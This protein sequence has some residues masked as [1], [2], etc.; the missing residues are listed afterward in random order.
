MNLKPDASKASLIVGNKLDLS[1]SRALSHER[2]IKPP[3]V[4]LRRKR[5]HSADK[6][7]GT[8]GGSL[9]DVQLAV[10]EA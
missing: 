1:L 3:V 4:T 7:L 2:A 5:R 9:Y 8:E 10:H 6:A